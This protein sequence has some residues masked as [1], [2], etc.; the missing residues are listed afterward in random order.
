MA[1]VVFAEDYDGATHLV[2]TQQSKRS[3]DKVH[4]MTIDREEYRAVMT[5]PFLNLRHI[6]TPKRGGAKS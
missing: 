1:Y 4:R 6:A 2:S 3:A 5:V